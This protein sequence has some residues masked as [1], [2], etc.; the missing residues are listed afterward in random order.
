MFRIVETRSGQVIEAHQT[1][2]EA[3]QAE[4]EI[5]A[6]WGEGEVSV[7]EA[8]YTWQSTGWEVRD[9]G[10]ELVKA[11]LPSEA[12]AQQWLKAN[13]DPRYHIVLERHELV[14]ASTAV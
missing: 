4:R 5:N 1:L 13:V 9:P 3:R 14:F 8:K 7:L 2:E 11:I 12:E 6:R 10:L